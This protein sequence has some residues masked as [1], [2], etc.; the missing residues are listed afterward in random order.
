V[1]ID[2]K[3]DFVPP[4]YCD[5]VADRCPETFPRLEAPG[6]FFLYPHRPPEI[7]STIEAAVEH[8]RGLDP[9]RKWFTWRDRCIRRLTR[10]R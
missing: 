5:Y 4:N 2:P 3:H 9:T 7:A 6:V 1:R 8:A 10:F